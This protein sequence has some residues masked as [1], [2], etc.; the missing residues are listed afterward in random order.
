MKRFIFIRQAGCSD[1]DAVAFLTAAGITDVTISN[2]ICTMVKDLKANGL[3]TKMKAIYPFVGGTAST[4]K[5]NLKDPRDLDAAFRLSFLGGWTHSATGALPNGTNA[6]ART[7][8]IPATHYSSANAGGFGVYSGTNATGAASAMLAGVLDRTLP[9][10][11]YY[12]INIQAKNMIIGDINNIITTT[13]TNY[14]GL[15]AVNRV[16]ANLSKGYRQGGVIGS[17]TV[18][19]GGIANAEILLAARKD[20]GLPGDGAAFFSLHEQRLSFINDSSLSDAE[21]LTLSGIVTNFQ[22]AQSRNV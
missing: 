20:T 8:F 22:T 19:Q 14:S 9:P 1:A 5:F 4:H 11:K 18:A 10:L 12:Q 15:F 16:N 6:Y 17:E 13:Y 2:A 3:W 21:Q 7:F